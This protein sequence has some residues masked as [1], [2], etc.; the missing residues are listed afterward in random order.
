MSLLI[1][2]AS[3]VCVCGCTYQISAHYNFR[4]T[5]RITKFIWFSVAV[6][7]LHLAVLEWYVL[8]FHLVPT[9][10]MQNVLWYFRGLCLYFFEMLIR[11]YCGG[12][13]GLCD[14]EIYQYYF[15]NKNTS[16]FIALPWASEM[17]PWLNV[18][19]AHIQWPGFYS[20]RTHKCGRRES[21]LQA[22][23]SWCLPVPAPTWTC[24]CAHT[25]TH[26]HPSCQ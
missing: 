9:L 8:P 14:R 19:D 13:I 5:H 18:F 12:K 7:P 21:V 20:Q 16:T 17:V 4:S 1:C 25:S 22:M 15:P 11:L 10:S 6:L 26:K 3:Y 2:W 23:T 24:K